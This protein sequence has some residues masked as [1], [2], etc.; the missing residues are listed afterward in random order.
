M[1]PKIS[2]LKKVKLFL[3]YR[4]E[5]RKSSKELLEAF[6]ARV[7]GASRI[8]TVLNI[9]PELIEEPYNLRKE[10]IDK[11]AKNYIREYSNELSKFLNSKNLMELYDFYEVKKVEK[12]SYL[13]VFGFSLFDSAK[14][15]RNLY[16]FSFSSIIFLII[17]LS[18]ILF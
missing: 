15:M 3:T 6:N 14:F 7:D 17:L 5:L 12:Y 16:I 4:K 2:F 11:L 10:D 8:Y 18:I 1:R 13:L 9:K